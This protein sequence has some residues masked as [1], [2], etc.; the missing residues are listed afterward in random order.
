[1]TKPGCEHPRRRDMVLTA[2]LGVLLWGAG[3]SGC[4]DKGGQPAAT[5]TSK[6]VFTSTTVMIDGNKHAMVAGVDCS[7]A[8]AQPDANP[9]ESGDLTTRINVHDDA[10]SVSLA[11]SDESPP[12]V[13]GFA[14]SLK[15]GNG[16]YQLPYQAPQSATQVQATKDGKSYTV[17]GTGQASTPGEGGT[18][19]VTF[20]IHVTCP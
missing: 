11:L 13:D 2:G 12:S 7:S 9:P 17:T 8:A 6:P 10:A 19:E 18:R 16:Q 20:G 14:V 5:S 3:L 1:M 15:A 4:A